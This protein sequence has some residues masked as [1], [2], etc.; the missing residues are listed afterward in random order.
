MLYFILLSCDVLF[1][2]VYLLKEM[3]HTFY[4]LYWIIYNLIL[5]KNILSKFKYTFGFCKI[6]V[7]YKFSYHEKLNGHLIFIIIYAILIKYV[8]LVSTIYLFFILQLWS[9]FFFSHPFIYL[10]FKLFTSSGD[11]LHYILVLYIYCLL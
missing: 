1:I 8:N 7:F 3:I 4:F 10:S 6:I 9:F 2:R 5:I 11:M